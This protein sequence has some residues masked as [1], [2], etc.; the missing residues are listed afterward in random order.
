MLA[1]N[2][3]WANGVVTAGTI[4]KQRNL[5]SQQFAVLMRGVQSGLVSSLLPGIITSSQALAHTFGVDV[6]LS[7]AEREGLLRIGEAKAMDSLNF[8]INRMFEPNESGQLRTQIDVL[9]QAIGRGKQAVTGTQNAATGGI[10]RRAGRRI[11]VDLAPGACHFCAEM[12]SSWEEK[13]ASE[14]AIPTGFHRSCTCM[15]S[16][17]QGS[18]G[19]PTPTIPFDSMV[20][21]SEQ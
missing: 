11:T 18:F 1:A 12:K 15:I 8:S 13:F 7:D 6:S 21:K 9:K 2:R 14:A 16:G 5:N 4:S 10:L 19:P 20:L 3:A 17:G